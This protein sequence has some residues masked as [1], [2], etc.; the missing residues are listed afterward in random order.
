[1]LST[2]QLREVYLIHTSM[3]K[4]RMNEEMYSIDEKHFKQL[5]YTEQICKS[6]S[7][8]I[9]ELVYCI[10]FMKQIK[11]TNSL[12]DR[13]NVTVAKQFITTNKELSN[14]F[15][16]FSI[17]L[18]QIDNI[19]ISFNISNIRPAS[20]YMFTNDEPTYFITNKTGNTSV[21]LLRN[22]IIQ[23]NS[24]FKLSINV[25]RHHSPEAVGIGLER[26]Q[27]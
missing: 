8:I 20:D 2:G 19:R 17:F 26:W 22:F 5:F 13:A 1:M 3:T 12:P 9:S 15:M 4:L 23:Y 7:G 18:D 11:L 10:Y 6:I 24:F 25:L 16:D 14:L 27:Q 21:Y